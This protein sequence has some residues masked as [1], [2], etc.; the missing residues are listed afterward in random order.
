MPC[1]HKVKLLTCGCRPKRRHLVIAEFIEVCL[2]EGT[3][4]D[5]DGGCLL[6]WVAMPSDYCCRVY[7]L[8]Y[9]P[10][11]PWDWSFCTISYLL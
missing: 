7:A 8:S 3:L 9:G 2:E 4:L 1:T 10:L 6:L 5:E 11:K